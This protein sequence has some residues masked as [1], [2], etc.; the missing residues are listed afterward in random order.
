MRSLALSFTVLAGLAGAPV[1]AQTTVP[2]TP[3]GVPPGANPA[4]GAR[5]GNEVGT[6]MSMPMGTRASNIDQSN[7]RSMI[8]PNLPSPAG[9]RERQ[10]GGLSA[11]RAVSAAGQPHRRGTAV[12]GDGA[13]AAARSLGA[14]G[15]DQQPE[16]Q[17]RG[18]A[19][20]AG[21][22]G[23]GR[24]RPRADH[25][26]DPVGD[27]GG[28]GVGAIAR[29]SAHCRGTRAISIAA[30]NG[31][32]IAFARNDSLPAPPRPS[33][34]TPMCLPGRYCGGRSGRGLH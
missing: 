25:A 6:G 13:D 14:D 18:D 10:C 1:L 3:Q 15:P 2:V 12:A 27:P 4:T 11:R 34:V 30:R 26:D 29:R 21:V 24:R 7:T 32:E 20:V 9:R 22:E 17:S 33:R 28:D 19:G 23:A 5:P 16:R 8:A 31:M